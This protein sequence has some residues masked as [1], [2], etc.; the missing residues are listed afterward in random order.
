MC[1]MLKSGFGNVNK[2][3]CIM[4]FCSVVTELTR[5]R[6]NWG[7]RCQQIARY[8]VESV[9]QYIM[10]QGRSRAHTTF[11]PLSNFKLIKPSSQP[12]RKR[13][14][15]LCVCVWVCVCVRLEQLWE[16]HR[17]LVCECQSFK[18][19]NQFPQVKR[20][21]CAHFFPTWNRIRNLQR[22]DLHMS[23]LKVILYFF[24]V[25]W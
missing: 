1:I 11:T 21:R 20:K 9:R 6:R 25:L 3:K 12:K 14:G 19:I 7:G 8:T 24:K 4:Q 18:L 17:D 15:Y 13:S 10:S 2:E 23:N 16:A 5:K 22:P